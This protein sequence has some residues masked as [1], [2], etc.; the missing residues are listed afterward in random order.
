M[1]PEVAFGVPLARSYS[2]SSVGSAFRPSTSSSGQ[3]Q[4]FKNKE[5][6]NRK[7]DL[8]LFSMGQNAGQSDRRG[9]KESYYDKAEKSSLPMGNEMY[10]EHIGWKQ[11]D[12][13]SPWS[14]RRNYSVGSIKTDSVK[15]RMENCYLQLGQGRICETVRHMSSGKESLGK[16]KNRS[17]RSSVM[18]KPAI[19]DI[20][21]QLAKDGS[22]SF[23]VINDSKA[24]FDNRWW[25]WMPQPIYPLVYSNP[26]YIFVDEQ[27]HMYAKDVEGDDLYLIGETV[28]EGLKHWKDCGRSKWLVLQATTGK[29]TGLDGNGDLV[30]ETSDF[31]EFIRDTLYD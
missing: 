28:D 13:I 14:M 2:E 12:V 7:T 20:R 21:L 8:R 31:E 6:K 19:D 25:A 22:D 27:N 16:S 4:F 24:F 18:N 29:W 11:S 17:G 30:D 15:E 9:A 26:F 23:K 10:N 3:R 5:R 1:D